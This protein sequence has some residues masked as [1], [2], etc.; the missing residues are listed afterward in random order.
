MNDMDKIIFFI[1]LLSDKY[2]NAE[3]DIRFGHMISDK[4][5]YEIFQKNN[6]I[7]FNFLHKNNEDFFDLIIIFIKT[8]KNFQ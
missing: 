4:T 6:V 8:M 2:N 1:I 3:I 5:T 7:Y